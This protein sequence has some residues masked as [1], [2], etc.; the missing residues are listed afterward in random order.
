ML[1]YLIGEF[2][3][4]LKYLKILEYDKV[5]HKLSTYCKTYIGKE[6]VN[7][8]L[9]E[10]NSN[11]VIASL[12]FTTEAISLIYRKGNVPICDIPNISV[13]LKVL[14]SIGVLSNLTLLNIARFFY[15][16]I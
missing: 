7:N 5:I 11:A 3:M 10:F 14:D 6:I 8:I 4:N 13:S 2:K 12:E 15:F 16:S 9:P 1:L